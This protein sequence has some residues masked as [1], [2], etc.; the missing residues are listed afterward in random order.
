[1]HGGLAH[2]STTR[3]AQ[4]PSPK[5]QRANSEERRTKNEERR[6]K[7]EE[8]RANSGKQQ[9]TDAIS[10]SI[11]SY[12]KKKYGRVSA[13]TPVSPRK[14]MEPCTD[15]SSPI[16]RAIND[17]GASVLDEQPGHRHALAPA[18]QPAN[19]E[20]GVLPNPH[21]SGRD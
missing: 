7:K 5:E 2:S 17:L 10:I 9:T 4:I 21:H 20:L 8:R 13:S 19:E 6:R 14:Q 18:E 11:S 16:R 3:A 15:H 1:M 12:L